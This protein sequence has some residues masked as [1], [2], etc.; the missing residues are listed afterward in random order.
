MTTVQTN[1]WGVLQRHDDDGWVALT[2]D[3]E[4][5]VVVIHEEDRAW[6][7]AHSLADTTGQRHLVARFVLVPEGFTDGF[8][9][10]PSTSEDPNMNVYRVS[11]RRTIDRRVDHRRR[12]RTQRRRELAS[13]A[14]TFALCLAA[15]LTVAAIMAAVS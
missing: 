3:D 2:C 5:T 6:T 14:R 1:I 11:S 7:L 10:H 9:D 4:T 13:G 12:A 15:I 8:P